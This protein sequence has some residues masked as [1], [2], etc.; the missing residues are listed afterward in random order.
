[1][2]VSETV[3]PH[4]A[5]YSIRETHRGLYSIRASN[6]TKH[7]KAALT[8]PISWLL[9]F[10]LFLTE[11]IV[12]KQKF[13]KIFQWKFSEN[14]FNDQGMFFFRKNESSRFCGNH[15]M[16]LHFRTFSASSS[17]K[18]SCTGGILLKIRVCFG[19]VFIWISDLR[20]LHSQS[21]WEKKTLTKKF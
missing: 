7:C 9:G 5:K 4:I 21:Q 17:P 3:R 2:S 18:I 13:N 19:D 15:T 16:H 20:F 12:I 14:I 10:F 6:S 11:R 1:M 8:S